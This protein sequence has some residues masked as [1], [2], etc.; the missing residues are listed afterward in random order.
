[1]KGVQP[2]LACRG[3]GAI[4]ASASLSLSLQMA[5]S[6]SW[7][8]RFSVL[9]YLQIMVF[10]NLFTLLSMPAEVLR[11]RKLVMQLLLDEQLE[12]MHAQKK[13]KKEEREGKE[14]GEKKGSKTAV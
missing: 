8:A 6:R 3:L 10:Y 7:H 9:T 13:N 11:I 2:L 12:V 5:G 14:G 1:M 4:A